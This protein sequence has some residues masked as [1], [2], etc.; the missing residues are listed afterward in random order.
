[1]EKYLYG[2]D[3]G[4][5]NSALSILDISTGK[6]VNTF[7]LPS[8]LYFPKDEKRVLIGHEAVEKYVSDGMKGRFIKS[9]KRVLSNK[10]FQNTLI[11]GVRYDLSDL[12]SLI[13]IALKKRADDFLNTEVKTVILGRPVFFDD[14]D[15]E[16]D[17]LAQK[18]LQMAAKQA[19]FE[20]IR[21][22]LEPIAAAFTYEK[23]LKEKQK[24]LVADL[25]GGTTDF[26]LIEL[27]PQKHHSTDRRQDILGTGGIYLGGDAFDA[28]FMWEKGTPHFGRG[29]K[30]STRPELWLDLPLSLFLNITSWEKMIFFNSTKVLQDLKRYYFQT[31]NHRKVKNLIELIE[32]NLGYS[33]FREIEKVK[34]DL[35]AHPQANFTFSPSGIDEIVEEEDFH[36]IIAGDLRKIE[37]Y[38][39]KF[40]ADHKVDSVFLTG[41]TSLVPAVQNLFRK[42]FGAEKIHSGDNFISV[43]KGLA[44]SHYLLN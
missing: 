23:S 25:G 4:T 42:R 12:V 18:R 30:Y 32:G 6:I 14:D 16:R 9:I 31:K 40:L 29:V 10:S 36:A 11:N 2:I 15:Q 33:I 27:D 44:Y 39:D 3:F 13:L 26:T 38:L 1:M 35:S 24:V 8:V 28:A 34:M 37:N 21:F 19:G 7:I 17:I 5:S 41:G 43:T 22:Q 20:T